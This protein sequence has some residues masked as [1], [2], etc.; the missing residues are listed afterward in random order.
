M[1]IDCQSSERSAENHLF[2]SKLIVES[3]LLCAKQRIALQAHRQDKIDFS[4]EASHYK[5]YFI[6]SLRLL[7]KSNHILNKHLV[8]GPKNAKTIQNEILLLLADRLLLRLSSK[9][10]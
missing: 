4:R 3:V 8:A 10:L 5:G 9:M 1:R 6:A 2:N 7:A